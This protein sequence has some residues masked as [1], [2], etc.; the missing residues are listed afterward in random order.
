MNIEFYNIFGTKKLLTK[1]LKNCYTG[2]TPRWIRF[3]KEQNLASE[4]TIPGQE[5][6][7]LISR[8]LAVTASWSLKLILS[9][10]GWK[11]PLWSSIF[12][13]V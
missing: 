4:L 8:R 5:K 7:D 9:S 11:R 6:M 10:R 12:S 1:L 13:E 2:V 3:I